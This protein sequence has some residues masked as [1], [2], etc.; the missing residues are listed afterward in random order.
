MQK[1]NSSEWEESRGLNGLFSDPFA[2]AWRERKKTVRERE[3]ERGRS[4][5]YLDVERSNITLSARTRK[6][7]FPS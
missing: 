6:L 1:A 7:F 4:G 2:A 5:F 3:R